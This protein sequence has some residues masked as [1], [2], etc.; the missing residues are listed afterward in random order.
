MKIRCLII[1]RNPIFGEKL[2]KFIKTFG[3]DFQV[4]T[5]ANIYEAIEAIVS[6]DFSLVLC[7][8]SLIDNTTEFVFSF[9]DNKPAV[10]LLI[11]GQEDYRHLSVLLSFSC[12]KGYIPRP[13]RPADLAGKVV[14]ALDD[15]FFQCN[16]RRV[17]CAHFIQIIEHKLSDYILRVFKTNEGIEGL[18]FFKNGILIDAICGGTEALEAAKRVLSWKNV[19][20]EIYNICPLKKNCINVN[21]AALIL[22]CCEK[23]ELSE[24]SSPV[25]GMKISPNSTNK[26]VGG[27]A[28][29]FLKKSSKK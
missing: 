9:I 5:V 24:R 16:V 22:Q 27:L 29:L 17:N 26:P 15:L 25:A 28:G 19:D 4:H 2:G 1:D 14:V 18:L 11:T 23:Q 7:E 12:F 6:T 21:M 20:I 13:V 10:S 8:P 3:D